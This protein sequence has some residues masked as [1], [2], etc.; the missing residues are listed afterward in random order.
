MQHIFKTFEKPWKSIKVT[1]FHGSYFFGATISWPWA[2]P[3]KKSKQNQKPG[4]C[5][6][7]GIDMEFPGI[8]D[9]ELKNLSVLDFWPMGYSR[10][11][12]NRAGRVSLRKWNFQAARGG[13]IRKIQ[14]RRGM[15]EDMEFPGVKEIACGISRGLFLV[16]EFPS[17]LTQFSGIFGGGWALLCLDFPGVAKIKKKKKN[18]RGWGN[19][20]SPPPPHL[21]SL[22]QWVIKMIGE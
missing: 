9:K 16:S 3:E 8:L 5:E 12:P 15:V 6:S 21:P 13:D 4:V 10:K 19:P 2:I 22:H 7:V 11:K 14:K 1:P 20:F 18:S 17:D